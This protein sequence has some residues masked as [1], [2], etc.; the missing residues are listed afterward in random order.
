MDFDSIGIAAAFGLAALFICWYFIGAAINRRRIADAARWVHRGLEPYKERGQGKGNL[1]IKWLATNA[2]NVLL[3]G[4]QSPFRGVVA[5][6]LLQSRDMVTVWL[7]DRMTGRRDILLLRCDL[8]KLP[9]WGLEIFRPRSILA[10]DARHRAKQEDWPV[11]T[12]VDGGLV[13]A[14]GGGKAGQFC[15]ALLREF[16]DDG[17]HLIR[18]GISRRSPHLTLAID[19]PDTLKS[20]PRDTLR[21]AERLASVTA[22][23]STS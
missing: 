7:I 20:D 3:E 11:E 13:V 15:A 17:R 23:Y 5:T 1:S 18:L 10:G 22:S 6:V 21:L 9:I 14:H 19:L 16:E 2:F 12:W 8:R 4:A